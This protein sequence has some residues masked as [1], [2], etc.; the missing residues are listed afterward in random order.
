MKGVERV[1]N[2]VENKITP[3]QVLE[4]TNTLRKLG[5]NP[6]HFGT[7]LINKSIQYIIINNIEFITLD[8]IYK[9]FCRK[10]GLKIKT[11]R[12]NVNNAITSRDIKKSKDN[13]E[14]VFGY[15]YDSYVF[16]PKY[17]IEEVARVIRT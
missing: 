14:T 12:N 13:F 3:S 17:F 6:T 10:Y 1:M 2:R 9:E 15:E 5:L 8:D 4:I 7:K 16:V 11:V